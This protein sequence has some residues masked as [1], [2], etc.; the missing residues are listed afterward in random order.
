VLYS[1][2]VDAE[3]G[4]DW[5][6][7]DYLHLQLGSQAVSHHSIESDY[8]YENGKV[9]DD[10]EQLIVC[11]PVGYF[12]NPDYSK[13]DYSD[14]RHGVRKQLR[15]RKESDNFYPDFGSGPEESLRLR[16]KYCPDVE[17]NI[18]RYEGDFSMNVM[19]W[20]ANNIP[21][22]LLK[23]MGYWSLTHSGLERPSVAR[24]ALESA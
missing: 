24:A 10:E 2:I 4:L 1:D 9:I 20:R 11:I 18:Q 17:I 16:A 23:T 12:D 6:G 22:K 14:W 8:E 3:C 7:K 21:P 5:K 19:P 15:Q 13:E